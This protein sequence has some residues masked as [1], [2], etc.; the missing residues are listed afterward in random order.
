M[1]NIHKSEYLLWTIISFWG[2]SGDS[3]NKESACNTGDTHLS[4]GSGRSPGKGMTAHS[5]ILAGRI[6]QREEP[7]GLQ[8][9]L[10][11]NNKHGV[12]SCALLVT[13]LCSFNLS[14]PVSTLY[15]SS[16]VALLKRQTMEQISTHTEAYFPSTWLLESLMHLLWILNIYLDNYKIIPY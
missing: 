5:S 11:S 12:S 4:P 9:L 10:Q 2:F 14:L 1:S 8:L 7:D 15:M 6:P 16:G 3:A 13:L